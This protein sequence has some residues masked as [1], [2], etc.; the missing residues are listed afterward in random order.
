[1]APEKPIKVGLIGAGGI[2]QIHLQAIESIEELE[3]AAVAD[4]APLAAEATAKR[5]GIPAVFQDYR[6]LLDL[7]DLDGVII[8]T[9]TALHGRPSIDALRAGKH[10]L[11]EKPMEA[12]LGM[13]TE[14]TRVAKETGKIL[15]VALKLRFS[16]QVAIAKDIVDGGALGRIYFAEAV[17]SRRRATPGPSFTR[18]DLAGFGVVSDL[19]IYPLD[20]ALYL[21][22]HP[23]PVV[24]SAVT[25]NYI[26]L[27]AAPV[28]G[29]WSDVQHESEVE[30][31]AA[32]WVRFDDGSVLVLKTSWA[33]NMDSLGTTYFLGEK[34]GLRLGV[35]EVNGSADGVSIYRDEFGA[36]TKVDVQGVTPVEN[37][38]LF[39]RE[40]R[41]WAEA[42][43]T[44][45]PSPVDPAGVLLATAIIDAAFQSADSGREVEVH[46]PKI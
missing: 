27:N 12:D 10:V 40:D 19:G 30:D 23:K 15:M 43:R 37:F 39:R 3:V 31:F 22:G 28:F 24:V 5:W 8:C 33:L 29:Q 7:G 16:P 21:M 35:G 17:A 13:A 2:A 1:M 4:I 46:A 45:S 42:V 25:S 20:T 44:N 11:V 34:A 36:M 9:P 6:D 32:A 41:A 18:K 38:E 14:M 26:S